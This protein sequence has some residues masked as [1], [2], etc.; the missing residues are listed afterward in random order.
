MTIRTESDREQLFSRRALFIGAVQGGIGLL[1]A[2]RMAYLSIF[3]QDKYELLAEDNRVSVRLIP[4]RRGWIVDRKGKPLAL[5]RPDYRLEMVPEQVDDLE[6]TLAQISRVIPLTADDLT[7][8]HA[9][10]KKY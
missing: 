6:A 8:I 3:E 10:I 4:P 9:D 5:N 2:G 7:R 1:L